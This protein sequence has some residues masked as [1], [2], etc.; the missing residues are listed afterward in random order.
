MNFLF[1]RNFQPNRYVCDGSNYEINQSF[2]IFFSSLCT[3]FFVS[4]PFIIY[5]EIVLD[6]PQECFVLLPSELSKEQANIKTNQT[7]KDNDQ[8]VDDDEERIIV[9]L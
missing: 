3:S 7:E 2:Q 8:D 6:P 1:V 9:S 4:G 5:G